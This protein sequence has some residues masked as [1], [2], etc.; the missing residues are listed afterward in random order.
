MVKKIVAY[1]TKDGAVFTDLKS[2]RM[3][4]SM[5]AISNLIRH[6]P[7]GDLRGPEELFRWIANNW[8]ELSVIMGSYLGSID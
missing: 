5:D 8:D 2:A 4:E 6:R 3:S 1:E 7:A